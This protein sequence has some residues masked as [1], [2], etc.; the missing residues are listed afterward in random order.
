MLTRARVTAAGAALAVVAAVWFCRDYRLP[1]AAQSR[2]L[3]QGQ[4]WQRK[5]RVDAKGVEQ[6]WASPGC[7]EMG[8]D[9]LSDF[10]AGADET[11]RHT[12]C[13]STGFWIDRYEAT[14]QSFNRF[15]LEGGYEQRRLWSE[16]GWLAHR[17][18][19][20]PYPE[21]P[22]FTQALQPRV[23][24]SW[25]EAQAYAAWRGGALPTEAQWE[26]AARGP[27]SRRYPWGERF[28]AGSANTDR[29][30]LRHPVPVGSY[31]SGASW[32]G[33]DDMAG[34]ISEWVADGYDARAY[35]FAS[36]LDPYTPPRGPLRVIRGGAWGGITGGSPA[37][38]RGARRAAL[39]AGARNN[40]RGVRVIHLG[41]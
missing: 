37:D 6:V 35:R 31:P 3:N 21:L 19:P 9:P 18:R 24:I 20:N 36:M 2:R 34:N 1:R 5:S 11:P 38:V 10:S 15:V 33:A 16:E 14:N 29:L 23:K 12:V 4:V 39:P 7:F 40:C 30:A 41:P 27:D 17:E 8:S 22:E 26:W 13:I 32:C 25:Y 28:V